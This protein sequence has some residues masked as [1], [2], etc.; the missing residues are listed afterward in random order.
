[1]QKLSI[2][3]SQQLRKVDIIVPILQM[4]TW[5]FTEISDLLKVTK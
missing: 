1:M 3:F 2:Y 4:K 5:W